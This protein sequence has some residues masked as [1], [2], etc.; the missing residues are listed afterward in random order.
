MDPF[1]NGEHAP[2]EE[3]E[4][5]NQER[6]EVEFFPIAK[7]VRFIRRFPAEPEAENQQRTV[8]SVHQGMDALG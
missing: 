1:H 7:R 4:E 6:P 2:C 5:G 3:D 8:P